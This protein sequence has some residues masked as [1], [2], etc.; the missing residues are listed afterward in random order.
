MPKVLFVVSRHPQS[1]HDSCITKDL[2]R[3]FV[4]HNW[5][6]YVVTLAAATDELMTCSDE[7]GCRVLRV[8]VGSYF[9]AKGLK[10]LLAISRIPTRFMAAIKHYF[11]DVAFDLILTHTPFMSNPRLLQPLKKKF[12][13]SI[14]LLL[15][16]MFPQNAIDLQLLKNNYLIAYFK[17]RELKML[18]YCDMLWCMSKG[19]VAYLSQHYS[20]AAEQQLGILH[21]FAGYQPLLTIDRLAIRQAYGYQ[22]D[23]IIALFGGNIG[24]AQKFENILGLATRCLNLRQAKFLVIGS[25]T[26]L[27]RMQQIA[28]QQALTNVQFIPQLLRSEYE[29][30][31][32]ACDIGLVSLD[33]RFTLFNFP[34][35]T[36]DYFKLQLPILA[37]LDHYSATDY[38]QFLVSEARAG[39]FA[40]AED[41]AAVY[42]SYLT[43]YTNG[44]LRRALAE[45]GRAFYVAKLNANLAYA[46]IVQSLTLSKI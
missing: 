28:Q 16:D 2:T 19:N 34:S 1:P 41:P 31:A 3:E 26:E 4:Q 24:I 9:N 39:L 12:N 23:D 7:E 10:K 8:N 15:W 32:A 13:C 29:A 40:L 25:G 46:K 38:G 11:S 35:K 33:E 45:N 20:L 30:I 22:D 42:A 14:Q 36:T 17:Q 27:K 21:N 43:L 37:S 44:D 6:V 18:S 5:Q